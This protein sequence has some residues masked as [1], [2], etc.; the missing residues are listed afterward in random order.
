MYDVYKYLCDDMACFFI[1]SDQYGPPAGL[2]GEKKKEIT[3]EFN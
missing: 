3:P 1:M 2:K